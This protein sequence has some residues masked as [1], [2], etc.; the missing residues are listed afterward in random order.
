MRLIPEVLRWFGACRVYLTLCCHAML[1]HYG[2]ELAHCIS[3]WIWWWPHGYCFS[4]R[5]LATAIS[6]QQPIPQIILGD[7]SAVTYRRHPARLRF[8]F[9][10]VEYQS[11]QSDWLPILRPHW[12]TSLQLPCYY[13]RSPMPL[14]LVK[15]HVAHSHKQYTMVPVDHDQAIQKCTKYSHTCFY[16]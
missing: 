14:T 2:L 7:V 9:C 15:W 6:A 8:L 13:Q 4:C 11:N 5:N 10:D 12:P 3:A 16:D 1:L